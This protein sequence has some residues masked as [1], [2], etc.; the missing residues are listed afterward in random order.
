MMNNVDLSGSAVAFRVGDLPSSAGRTSLNS[1]IQAIFPARLASLMIQVALITGLLLSA[2]C[3]SDLDKVGQAPSASTQSA[4]AASNQGSVG[5]V[6]ESLPPLKQPMEDLVR[7]PAGPFIFGASERQFQ[8]FLSL[9]VYNFPGMVQNMRQ[10]FV[11]PPQ[12]AQTPEFQIDRFEVTNE[13]FWHFTWKT[14]YAPSHPTDFLKHWGKEKVPPEWSLTFPV[15]W[16]NQKDAQAFCEWRGGRLPTEEEWEKSARGTKEGYFP[17][18][19]Q[20]PRKTTANFGN[21]QAESTG[22]RPGDVSSF[23]VFDLGGNVSEMT[24]T[25]IAKEND[26][27]TVVKGGNFSGSAREM[28]CYSRVLIPENARRATVGFR[29]VVETATAKN[30]ESTW[31]FQH[32]MPDEPRIPRT[33]PARREEA[34]ADDGTAAVENL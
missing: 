34:R 24:L 7:I 14:K 11:M 30:K 2:R 21:K 22:N 20:M 31:F 10:L 26:Y 19:I 9:S 32:Q 29:C 4:K 15:V 18:G 3:H 13:H 8:F 25:R 12:S 6:T 16:V 28:L 27:Q 5:Q 1:G 23:E 17:W 33:Q